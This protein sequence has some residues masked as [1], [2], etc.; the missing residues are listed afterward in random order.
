M[1]RDTSQTATNQ[2][3]PRRTKKATTIKKKQPRRKDFLCKQENIHKIQIH[4]HTQGRHKKKDNDLSDS[5][6]HMR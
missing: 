4:A 1:N 6:R 2:K 3:Q 5:L